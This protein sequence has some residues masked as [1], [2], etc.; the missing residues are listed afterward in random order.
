MLV[1]GMVVVRVKVMRSGGNHCCPPL[2]R[3]MIGEMWRTNVT[4]FMMDDQWDFRWLT[5]GMDVLR[6]VVL[7]GPTGVLVE[8]EV[9]LVVIFEEQVLVG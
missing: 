8:V 6:K 1:V 9:G 3:G 5:A 4:S 2:P 7:I